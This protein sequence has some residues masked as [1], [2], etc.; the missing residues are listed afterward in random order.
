MKN[1]NVILTGFMGCGKST[2]GVRLSY[3][4]RKPV[5]DTDKEIERTEKR[6]IPAIFAED[7]EAAFRELET[8]CLLRLL[9]TTQDKVISVGGGLPV[10]E[11]NRELLHSLGTIVYLR[12]KPE[13]I[14]G[15]LKNDTGRPLLQGEDPQKKIRELMAERSGF[16]EDAADVI[17]DVDGKEF[18]QVL[19][20]IERKLA[21]F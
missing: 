13:T 7:G 10:R 16:Y 21:A 9:E 2:V 18:D 11:R 3:R 14:Y 6:T 19:D 5:I 15:R 17:V 20:E 1:G 8:A 12:A 4:L